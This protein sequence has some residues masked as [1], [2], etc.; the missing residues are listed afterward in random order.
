MTSLFEK[1]GIQVASTEDRFRAFEATAR[2]RQDL[3]PTVAMHGN[4]LDRCC[5]SCAVED[6]P[7]AGADTCVHHSMSQR[8]RA[9]S[10]T[11]AQ[12]MGRKEFV[13]LRKFRGRLNVGPHH[14]VD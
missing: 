2:R 7:L 10:C 13:I 4:S 5:D 8:S 11:Q 6:Q 3:S 1:L 9:R 14:K 12:D